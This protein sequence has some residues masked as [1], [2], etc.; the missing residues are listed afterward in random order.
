VTAFKLSHSFR[1][2]ISFYS[3]S[4]LHTPLP[5]P[6]TQCHLQ[7]YQNHPLSPALPLPQPPFPPVF[8]PFFMCVFLY[9]HASCIY[10]LMC[11]HVR[12]CCIYICTQTN[13]C[14]FLVLYMHIKTCMCVVHIYS[15]IQICTFDECMFEHTHVHV[16]CKYMFI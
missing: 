15:D 8:A 10:E 5:D 12:I 4:S 13:I 14:M 11:T 1:V 6:P 16:C 7:T 9:M 3:S 2:F